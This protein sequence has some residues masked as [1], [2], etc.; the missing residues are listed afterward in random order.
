[1]V[2]GP[3]Q[4]FMYYSPSGAAVRVLLSAT[5]NVALSYPTIAAMAVYAVTFS[6]IAVR[7]FRWE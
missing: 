7:Y 4:A 1:M 3:L 5:F 2:S 6:A